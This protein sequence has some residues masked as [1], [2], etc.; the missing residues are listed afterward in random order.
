[1]FVLLLYIIGARHRTSAPWNEH[2]TI[3]LKFYVAS[4]KALW[5]MHG[6]RER[7]RGGE[8]GSLERAQ[9]WVAEEIGG[10]AD[11]WAESVLQSARNSLRNCTADLKNSQD[12][13]KLGLETRIPA[14]RYTPRRQVSIGEFS[15]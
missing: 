12:L 7:G 2:K 10:R 4:T 6:K 5:T 3:V 9:T 8:Q 14:G 1:M 13:C 15:G 11:L